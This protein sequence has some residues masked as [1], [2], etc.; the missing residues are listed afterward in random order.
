MPSTT[1]ALAP[2]TALPPIHHDIGSG[3]GNAHG[4]VHG[5]GQGQGRIDYAALD[6]QRWTPGQ[7]ALRGLTKAVFSLGSRL[8]V[9]GE[10]NLP[11][12]G[13]CIIAANHLCLLDAPLLFTRMQRPVILLADGWLREVKVAGWVLGEIV[14]SIFLHGDGDEA[15]LEDALTVLRSGGIVALS[16]EGV[17]SPQGLTQARSGIAYLARLAS[18]PVVPMAAWGHERLVKSW[19]RL[20][21]S[22]VH[23]RIGV[24]LTLPSSDGSRKSLQENTDLIMR[25]IAELL[26]PGYRG[27]YDAPQAK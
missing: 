1:P 13:G 14:N 27:V 3:N 23:I 26:P 12:T 22:D 19:S 24:P 4:A 7:S 10:E 21:R 9:S 25:K 2:T 8:D 16:P 17:R 6:Y 5:K 15:G 18:V 20:R 11:S